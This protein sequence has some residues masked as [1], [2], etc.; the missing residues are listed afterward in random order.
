MSFSHSFYLLLQYL[1]Q[2]F[3]YHWTVAAFRTVCNRRKEAMENSKCSYAQA[4]QMKVENKQIVSREISNQFLNRG[5]ESL[6]TIIYGPG[7]ISFSS[8]KAGLF[9]SIFASTLGDMGYPFPNFHRVAVLSSIFI[10]AREVWKLIKNLI[11]KNS[12]AQD[13]ITLIGF[14]IN[15]ELSQILTKLFN[16][17]FKKSFPSRMCQEGFWRTRVSGHHRLSFDPSSS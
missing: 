13:K 17:F 7:F 12:T 2:G 8:D 1:S 15:P 14:N 10:T 4:V 6:P 5:R 11:P 3:W 16:G 9:A